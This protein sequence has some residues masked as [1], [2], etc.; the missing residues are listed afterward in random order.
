MGVYALP[1]RYRSV[2]VEQTGER[3]WRTTK[4]VVYT[5]PARGLHLD[6]P[7]G[8][9]TDF[10]T[11]PQFIWWL[12]PTYGLYTAATIL[13]D[14]LITDVLPTGQITSREVDRVF[15]EAMQSLRV[16]WPRRWL[17]WAGVRWGALVNRK[18]RAG[19]LGT[20]P[21]VLAISLLAL[22]FVLPAVVVL[23][24][25]IL[26]NLLEQLTKRRH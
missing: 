24:S 10:A 9:P 5:D 6:V 7:T 15:R 22:P 3:Y 19:S 16:S 11:I 25:L 1:F 12:C 20:I 23:P 2:A 13:H 4:P 8:Y 26:F 14:H 21:G 18:R 17:M